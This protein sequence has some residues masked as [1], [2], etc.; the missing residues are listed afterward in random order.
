MK[1]RSESSESDSRIAEA[2]T[3]TRPGVP[4]TPRPTESRGRPLPALRVG[5]VAATVAAALSFFACGAGAERDDS[6]A[7][8]T[9]A[10]DAGIQRDAGLSPDAEPGGPDLPARSDVSPGPSGCSFVCAPLD[11]FGE[12]GPGWRLDFGGEPWRAT[13]TLGCAEEGCARGGYAVCVERPE[14]V[15]RCVCPAVDFERDRSFRLIAPAGSDP[16]NGA[17]S[18]IRVVCDDAASWIC[19]GEGAGSSEDRRIYPVVADRVLLQTFLVGGPADDRIVVGFESGGEAGAGGSDQPD[20]PAIC[21]VVQRRASEDWG[22]RQRWEVMAGEGDDT[23]YAAFDTEMVYGQGGDDT[24]FGSPGDDRIQGD[25]EE[26][27]TGPWGHDVLFGGLGND[28]IWGGPGD[29]ILVGGPDEPVEGRRDVDVLWG[30]VRGRDYGG[31]AEGAACN[32]DSGSDVLSGGYDVDFLFGCDGEDTLDGGPGADLLFGCGWP[33]G[34]DCDETTA[35]VLEGGA[36]DGADV[37]FGSSGPD[38]LRGGGGDDVLFGGAG[39]DRL[40][41]GPGADRL[42]GGEGPDA[43]CDDAGDG[44]ALD[45]G[46]GADFLC[47]TAGDED[48]AFCGPTDGAGADAGRGADDT[49][50]G[51]EDCRGCDPA[52]NDE[53]ACRAACVP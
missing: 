30:D 39:G 3:A 12:E 23:V 37:L 1:T 22:L 5:A 17:G 27:D 11:P 10:R 42:D 49:W 19:P 43:L 8:D 47:D 21:T 18:T 6:L 46:P 2:V 36:G 50:A 44:D 31:G 25:Y 15:E 26:A 29:D 28:V 41:G 24:I 20:A 35:N 32:P 53:A 4:R 52:R 38:T 13:L 48:R 33:D 45:G 34:R 9:V 7:A 51:C 14:G 40:E 16:A